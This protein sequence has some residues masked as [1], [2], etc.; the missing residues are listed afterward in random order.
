MGWWCDRLWFLP[1]LQGFNSNLAFKWN[2][3][4]SGYNISVKFIPRDGLNLNFWRWKRTT[5]GKITEPIWKNNNF[6]QVECH[7]IYSLR[8]WIQ[9]SGQFWPIRPPPAPKGW[10]ETQIELI[11]KIIIFIFRTLFENILLRTDQVNITVIFW[12]N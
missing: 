11:R 3:T 6:W 7:P 12:L 10:K 8:C 4:L 5:K 9:I 1:D 2:N